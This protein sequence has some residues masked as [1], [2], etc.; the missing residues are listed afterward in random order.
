MNKREPRPVVRNLSD[1]L[2]TD[3]DSILSKFKPGAKVTV[4]VR[5]PMVKDG[6]VVIGN[7]DISE[8]VRVALTMESRTAELAAKG[9]LIEPPNG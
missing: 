6:D 9:L 2:A 7:D 5:C 3:L 4:I 8:A 1:Q